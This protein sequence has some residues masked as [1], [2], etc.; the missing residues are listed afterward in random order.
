MAEMFARAAVIPTWFLVL[1]VGALVLPIP[2]TIAGVALVG[3]TMIIA[4]AAVIR[5]TLTSSSRTPR[6]DG[7]PVPLDADG[8]DLNRMDSDQ[9]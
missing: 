3:G 2:V 5:F 7:S 8:G 6:A 9:G 1:G 4:T